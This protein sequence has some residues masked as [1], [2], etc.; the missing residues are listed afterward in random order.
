MEVSAMYSF[1]V[2]VIIVIAVFEFLK[3]TDGDL[4]TAY[5]H[6]YY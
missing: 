5:Y 4:L 3:L 6:G 1:I 2:V